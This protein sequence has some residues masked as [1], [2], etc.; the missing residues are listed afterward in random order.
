M[1]HSPD[2]VPEV[3]DSSSDHGTAFEPASAGDVTETLASEASIERQA[4]ASAKAKQRAAV[5]QGQLAVRTLDEWKRELELWNERVEPLLTND[6]GRK[7][8]TSD[9]LVRV[10]RA[11]Y[12]RTPRGA[13]Q[14][15]ELRSAV[16]DELAPLELSLNDP[17]DFSL[18]SPALAEELSERHEEAKRHRD[19]LRRDRTEIEALVAVEGARIAEP[20]AVT[21][22]DAVAAQ[23]LDERARSAKLAGEEADRA[24][25]KAEQRVAAAKAD[26]ILTAG[27]DE[28]GRIAA[29]ARLSQR[30]A[31]EEIAAKE[32]AVKKERLVAKAKSAEVRRYLGNFFEDGYIQPARGGFG[33]MRGDKYGP[34]SFRALETSGALAPG[35]K[36]LLQ[37][38][39]FASDPTH[40]GEKNDRP[41]W[42]F[43]PYPGTWSTEDRRFLE[44][45]QGLLRELGPTLVELKLLA[46]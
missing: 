17:A 41:L 43:H 42:R 12:D 5:R 16:S 28:A 36:G 37:L 18:P 7:V 33:I 45:A 40:Q 30:K 2:S 34:V 35:E 11:V 29:A 3:T 24:A 38:N 22:R 21:L 20:A 1:I 8:A 9:Q 31:E 27:E 23:V 44:Q 4:R 13:E 25:R 10:F 26:A 32:E 6:D 39:A 19:E 46:P 14:E 15:A